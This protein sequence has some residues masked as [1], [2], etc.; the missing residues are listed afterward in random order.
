MRTA[1]VTGAAGGIGAAIC[2][3]LAA[4]GYAVVVADIDEKRADNLAEELTA[5]GYQA[6]AVRTD[7]SDEAEVAAMVAA[8]VAA[9]G[10]LDALVNTAAAMGAGPY[11]PDADLL[12]MTSAR[13]D[14]SFSITLRGPMLAC[15]HALPHMIAAGSGTIV[16]ISSASGQR[17]DFTRIAYGAAKAG[18]DALTRHVSTRYGKQGIRCNSIA[19]GLVRTATVQ[20]M[21][22]ADLERY[23]SVH[24]TPYL[25]E[26]EDVANAVA[27]LISEQARFVTGQV[28]GVDGGELAHMVDSLRRR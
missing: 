11:G 23:E 18:V 7:V 16:N 8:T 13:W 26:P 2:R 4:R 20:Q 1:I 17:G 28:I 19:P 14:H 15:K 10:G 9:F 27:Y 12:S 24:L 21:A 25:G 22:P 3:E 5:A 6:L